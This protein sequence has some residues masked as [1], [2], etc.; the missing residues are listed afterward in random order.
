MARA[1]AQGAAERRLALTP[2][3]LL[4]AAG[5]ADLR[6]ARLLLSGSARG[7]FT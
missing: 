1:A 7:A 5:A 3:L 2:A 6:G 4:A